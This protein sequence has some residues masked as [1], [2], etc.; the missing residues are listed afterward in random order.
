M[1]EPLR[2]SDFFETGTGNCRLMSHLCAKLSETAPTWGKL[3]SPWAEYVAR[4]LWETT[5]KPNR[6]RALATRLTQDHRR[7]AKGGAAPTPKLP[8]PP[9]SVCRLCGA[10]IKFSRTYCPTCNLI[11]AREGMIE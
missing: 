8:S 7:Q 1:H 5:S 3:V 9:P 6:R 11:I 2:R 10:I 4:T